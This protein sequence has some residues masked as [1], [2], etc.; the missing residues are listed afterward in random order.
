MANGCYRATLDLLRDTEV[1]ALGIPA[2]RVLDEHDEFR[3]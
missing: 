2:R 3:V 1:P